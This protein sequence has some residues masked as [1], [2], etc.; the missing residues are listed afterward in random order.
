MSWKGLPWRLQIELAEL[1]S[2]FQWFGNDSLDLIVVSHLDETGEWEVFAER[3]TSESV[4]GE[5]TSEIGMIGEKDAVHVP[6]LTFVPV[7]ALEYTSD[8]V[9]WREL[10]SVG[11]HSDTI[12]ETQ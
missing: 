12:V 9:D 10:I 11:L 2:Q 5:D 3:M 6:G 7:G 8:R 1:L 4:I